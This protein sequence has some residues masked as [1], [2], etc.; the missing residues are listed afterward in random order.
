MGTIANALLEQVVARLSA[1]PAIVDGEGNTVTR[2]RRDHLTVVPRD[3]APAFHVVDGLEEK[4]SG[5]TCAR[6]EQAFT[7]MV[8]V[9]SD[10]GFS[11]ADPLKM[12]I[13][14]RL[15]PITQQWADGIELEP[16]NITPNAEL[17]DQDILRLDMEFVF[18]YTTGIWTLDGLA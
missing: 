10:S 2:I 1:A 8:F 18:R 13:Y 15:N 14:R 6:R 4:K 7:V 5:G 9:R 16:G 3:D 17:A 12:E 11:A